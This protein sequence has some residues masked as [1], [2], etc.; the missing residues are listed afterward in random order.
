M[1]ETV[2][3]S[4]LERIQKETG[5]V[6]SRQTDRDRISRYLDNGGEIPGSAEVLPVS[7]INL[8]TTN[9]TYFEREAHHFDRLIEEILPNLDALDPQ[10]PIRI[11]SA[12]CSS[13]EESYS[14]ALRLSAS[15]VKFSRPIEIIG[16]DISEEMIQ[17]ARKGVYSPRSVHA[18][19]QSVLERYF[20]C[21]DGYYHILPFS[22]LS[23][24]FVSGNVF[25]PA[26]WN[27]LGSFDVIFSRNMM[28]YF[29]SLKNRE[30]LKR[31]KEHLRGYL[32]LGHADDHMQAKELFTPLRTERGVIYH[33]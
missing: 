3:T 30:L 22:S 11:L 27:S 4:L 7:L 14:I 32:I 29:D 19:G 33:V 10:K 16:I 13:G 23:V 18:L 20:T 1:K 15:S 2:I 24:R 6:L 31:F 5:I 8:V 28:I 26:L 25:D 17:K 21:V 12:P 9:E